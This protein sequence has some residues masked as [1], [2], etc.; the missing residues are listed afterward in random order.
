MIAA[1]LSTVKIE[2]IETISRLEFT[3]RGGEGRRTTVVDLKLIYCKECPISDRR[4]V[5]SK[6]ITAQ[7][8]LTIETIFTPKFAMRS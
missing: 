1:E 5:R 7:L 8:K 3:I 2:L 4:R 6:M